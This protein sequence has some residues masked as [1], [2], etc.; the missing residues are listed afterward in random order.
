MGNVDAALERLAHGKRGWWYAR[1]RVWAMLTPPLEVWLVVREDG[2]MNRDA[3]G[4]AGL[5]M[6]QVQ[7]IL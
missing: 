5:K 6:P 2:S 4:E 7:R 3:T 1:K